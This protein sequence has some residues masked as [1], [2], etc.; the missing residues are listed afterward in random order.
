MLENIFFDKP[1]KV[2]MRMSGIGLVTDSEVEFFAR[3]HLWECGA[4]EEEDLLHVTYI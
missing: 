2:V 3:E 1:Q 4:N